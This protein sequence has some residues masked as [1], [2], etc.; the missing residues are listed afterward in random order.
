MPPG[1]S[2]GL[3]GLKAV[4]VLL[5][6]IPVV[7]ECDAT[8]ASFPCNSRVQRKSTGYIGHFASSCVLTKTPD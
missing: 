1:R 5:K 8:G 7:Q 6:F 3:F 4:Y 2:L